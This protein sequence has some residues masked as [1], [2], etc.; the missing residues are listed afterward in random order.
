MRGRRGKEACKEQAN[1]PRSKDKSKRRVMFDL[2][3]LSCAE[4]LSVSQF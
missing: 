1:V 3:L 4:K 2:A